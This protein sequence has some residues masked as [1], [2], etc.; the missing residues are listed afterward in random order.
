MWYGRKA[1][2]E[3]LEEE[4]ENTAAGLFGGDEETP[5]RVTVEEL[6]DLLDGPNPP[7]V[8]DVRTRS[9]Y[10]NDAARIRGDVRVLPDAVVEWAISQPKDVF[11]VAYCT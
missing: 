6:H 3:T 8:L 9:S 11:V 4:R 2:H 10:I 7:V 1:E 5:P